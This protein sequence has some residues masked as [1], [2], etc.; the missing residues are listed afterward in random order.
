VARPSRP[1]RLRI[2]L[3]YLY[4]LPVVVLTAVFIAW[5][6]I[7]SVY[8]ATLEWNFVSPVQKYVGLDN[9]LHLGGDPLFWNAVGNTVLYAAVLVPA[10]LIFPLALAVALSRIGNH[11]SRTVYRAILFTPTVVS[12][13]AASVVWLWIFNPVGGV[14]NQISQA[15]GGAGS[16]WLGDPGVAFWCV[17]A[18]CIWKLLGFNLLLFSTALDSVPKVLLEAAALD[19]ASGWTLL[20]RIKLPLIAP[21]F[22]F[23]VVSTTIFITEDVFDAISILTQGGPYG[24][25]TNV[26]YFLYERSF[27]EF[28]VG[29]ASAVALILFVAVLMITRLQFRFAERHVHY[30]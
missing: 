15:M 18:V 20:R 7:Y 16:A 12:F 10:L 11:R 23:V 9:F 24:S 28:N 21:T 19:G 3:P 13:S 30:S 25:T 6:L 1:A 29:E 26:L 2:L 4:I 8:L 5:P 22:F 14:L 17:A 27:K